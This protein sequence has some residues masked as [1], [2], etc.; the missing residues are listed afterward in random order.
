MVPMRW[1]HHYGGA[2]AVRM[3]CQIAVYR[4]GT[5][6]VQFGGIEMGQGLNTKAVQVVAKEMGVGIDII[7]VKPSNNLIS[8]NGGLTGGSKGSDLI[9]SSA[10]IAGRRLRARMAE[11]EATLENPTW[12]ELVEACYKAGMDLSDRHM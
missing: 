12:E 7:Q 11:I 1:H 8:N 5:I 2:G 4:S 10:V 9:C 6:S 3:T